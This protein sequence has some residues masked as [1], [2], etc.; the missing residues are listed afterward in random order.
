MIFQC[1]H[2]QATWDKLIEPRRYFSNNSLFGITMY[3]GV[4][5]LLID[6][7]IIL[8]PTPS[9]WSLQMPLR[10]RVS[11]TA[12]FALGMYLISSKNVWIILGQI[13]IRD[14]GTLSCVAA[15]ARLPTLVF[16]NNTTDYTCKLLI[17]YLNSP[18]S[19]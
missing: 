8:L 10:H 14:I 11:T 3:Q 15:L 12:L 7:A 6:V 17:R 9:T 4:T 18:V 2:V 13:V 5:M 19:C 1:V 16:Q